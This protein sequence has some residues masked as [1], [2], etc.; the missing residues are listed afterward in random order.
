VKR[1]AALWPLLG[2]LVAAPAASAFG[3]SIDRIHDGLLASGR[4]AWVLLLA[5]LLVSLIAPWRPLRRA[6]GLAATVAATAHAT[7]AVRALGGVEAALT[8]SGH[9]LGAAALLLLLV[10]FATSFP[11]TRRWLRRWAS[12]HR[13]VYLAA[14]LVALHA[15]LGAGAIA[16]AASGAATTAA[17]LLLRAIRGLA[18]GRAAARRDAVEGASPLPRRGAGEVAGA[19]RHG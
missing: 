19:D 4:G 3:G 18:T 8:L 12:L 6:L 1:A 11:R 7:A 2:V 10:L 9:R 5:S 14:G 17:L 15:L 13:L 16:V